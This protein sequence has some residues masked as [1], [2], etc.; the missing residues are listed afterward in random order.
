MTDSDRPDDSSKH[1]PGDGPP[2][3]PAEPP[4][5]A[6]PPPPARRDPAF[7]IVDD[8]LD[9]PPPR[10]PG[11][12][13]GDNEHV[14]TLVE[15]LTELRYRILMALAWIAL[16]ACVTLYYSAPLTRMILATASKVQFI[17]LS[18]MEIFFTEMKI[19]LLAALIVA[20]P[21]ITWQIWGFIRPGLKK[22]EAKILS[23]LGP[24]TSL[25]FFLGALFAYKLVIPFGVDFLATFTLEGVV[26]QYSLEGYTS[27]V[28]YLTL[29]MGLIFESPVVLVFLAKLGL[30]SSTSLAERR[31]IVILTCFIVAAVV[32]PTPDMVTQTLVALPMW[33]LFEL[34]LVGLR[35]LKL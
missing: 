35:F 2:Q 10:P 31:K 23:A 19:G 9:V 28:L 27:F 6:A 22:D 14:M 18:P 20:V 29:T 13:E 26:A 33:A 32:T 11:S 8:G 30:V 21:A 4:L 1:A 3:P 34:T 7:E 16:A 5:P 24:I 12:D 25:L 17:A 15:H